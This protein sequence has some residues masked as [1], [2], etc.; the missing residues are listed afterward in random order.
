MPGETLEEAQLL[1]QASLFEV[2][3]AERPERDRR[4]IR[5]CLEESFFLAFTRLQPA[6]VFEI[7]AHRAEFSRRCKRQAP[8]T[9]IIAFEA[10][11]NVFEAARA[12]VEADGVE[13]VHKAVSNAAGMI[14]F[15][16]PLAA[17]DGAERTTMGSMLY[18]NRTEMHRSYE[19]AAV[20]LDSVAPPGGTNLIWIDVEGAIGAVL[21]GA[22]ATLSNCVALYAELESNADRWPGQMVDLEVIRRLRG[23]GL[24]PIL[25]DV[26]RRGWQYNALFIR[27]DLV[28]PAVLDEITA[29]FRRAVVAK[30]KR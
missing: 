19:V 20:T 18:D 9:R 12:E 15:N 6:T 4:R 26:Q 21:E 5:D 3:L 11:P 13:F 25:R 22:A 1:L 10:N 2:I 24:V 17:E 28:P 30:L 27:P 14:R 23:I 29:H 16:V 7:G 8:A